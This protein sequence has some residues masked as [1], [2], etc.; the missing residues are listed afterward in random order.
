MLGIGPLLLLL[1]GNLRSSWHKVSERSAIF[2]HFPKMCTKFPQF[3][4][5]SDILST[6]I[7]SHFLMKFCSSIAGSQKQLVNLHSVN[8]IGSIQM[9]KC[10]L[11]SSIEIPV[12]Q[13]LSNRS[14]LTNTIKNLDIGNWHVSCLITDTW[15]NYGRSQKISY[16]SK[17]NWLY[18]SLVE[19]PG[20]G[21][22]FPKAKA[23][24]YSFRP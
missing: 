16:K 22:K 21:P 3:S 2:L 9:D 6:V 13:Q 5:V 23:R 18:L 1:W 10:V 20:K 11:K 12:F 14:N 17:T 7:F 15:G 8:K 4:F 19:V 24:C